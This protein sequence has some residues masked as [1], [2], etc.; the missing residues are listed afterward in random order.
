MSA[1]QHAILKK[2][3]DEFDRFCDENDYPE[4]FIESPEWAE[5]IELAK[6][7]L[8]AFNYNPKD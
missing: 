8:K 5:I 2:F 3:R 7:V 4:E 1:N 6:E